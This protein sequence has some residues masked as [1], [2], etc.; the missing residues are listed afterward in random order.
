MKLRLEILIESSADALRRLFAVIAMHAQEVT[1]IRLTRTPGLNLG[2][3]RLDLEGAGNP[4]DLH[5]ALLQEPSVREASI[6]RLDE[7]QQGSVR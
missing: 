3:M 2:R 6:V 7:L 5:A 1:V 4:R